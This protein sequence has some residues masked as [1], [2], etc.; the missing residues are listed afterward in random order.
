MKVP[1]RRSL[2]ALC[3]RSSVLFIH[4][5]EGLGGTNV[6]EATNGVGDEVFQGTH[7]VRLDLGYNIVVTV[8]EI[9][10]S[11]IRN[12][13]QCLVYALKCPYL[14][15]KEDKRNWQGLYIQSDGS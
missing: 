7:R 5:D 6:V 15:P 13:F 11:H 4:D 10:V 14:Y 12:L 9:Y 8:N 3:V 2:L 1:V